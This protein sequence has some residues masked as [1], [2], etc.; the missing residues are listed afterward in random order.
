[1]HS[2]IIKTKI[3]EDA[4][5]DLATMC[6]LATKLLKQISK[7]RVEAGEGNEDSVK[8]VVDLVGSDWHLDAVAPFLELVGTLKSIDSI[9]MTKRQVKAA[10]SWIHLLSYPEDETGHEEEV[11]E[12]DE[13]LED[14]FAE[15]QQ[16]W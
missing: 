6:Q 2:F 5:V 12:I 13:H 9:R 8:F 15:T 1:M 3:A 7:A 10:F 16:Q 14:E 4:T 11:A